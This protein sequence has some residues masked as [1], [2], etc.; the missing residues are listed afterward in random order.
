VPWPGEIT[1]PFPPEVPTTLPAPGAVFPAPPLP[2]LSPITFAESIL[3]ELYDTEHAKSTGTL[4][5]GHWLL[6]PETR[7]LDP[8]KSQHTVLKV[9][10]AALLALLESRRAVNLDDWALAQVVID[11]SDRVRAYLQALARVVAGKA[12][13]AYLAAENEAEQH[14]AHAR[15]AVADAIDTTA[16]TRVSIRLA[17]R[18]HDE[19]PMTLGALRKTLAGR[20]KHLT[21]GAIE[22]A[23][24]LGWVAVAE[25]GRTFGPGSARPV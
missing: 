6:L 22:R 2:D 16:E 9:K 19:G 7:E 15:A 13:A 12:R 8:F 10:V 3:D 11:T 25:G 4:A 5:S 18:V 1:S 14:R 21:E 17:Q 24:E 23:I 20:D